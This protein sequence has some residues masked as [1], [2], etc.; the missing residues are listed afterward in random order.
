M[1][2]ISDAEFSKICKRH[3][4]TQTIWYYVGAVDF[5]D[6]GI[7]LTDDQ[8]TKWI[9]IL[10]AVVSTIN[11]TVETQQ[12]RDHHI[13]AIVNRS[14]CGSFRSAKTPVRFIER[15]LFESSMPE[16]AIA[17]AYYHPACTDE[18]RVRFHLKGEVILPREHYFIHIGGELDMRDE[19]Y[20]RINQPID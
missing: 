5:L 20:A 14:P 15:V 10:P 11:K 9:K 6:N 12:F 19:E 2:R 7:V 1:K 16:L 17:S 8:L 13:D 18:M 4:N 3:C